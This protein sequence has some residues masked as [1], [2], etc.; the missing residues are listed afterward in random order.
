MTEYFPMLL[1]QQVQASGRLEVRPSRVLKRSSQA[2][3]GACCMEAPIV[4]AA[5]KHFATGCRL[6]LQVDRSVL[7]IRT[8]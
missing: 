7:L 3:E 1:A 4:I 6:A 5:R 2:A 8:R